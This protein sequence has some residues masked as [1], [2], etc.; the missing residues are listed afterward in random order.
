MRV[1][2]SH[3]AR[4]R[5]IAR[6]IERELESLDG[7]ATFRDEKNIAGGERITERIRGEI[8]A[9]DELVVIFSAASQVSSWVNIEIG[10]AW[11]FDKRIVF[12]LEKL[13]PTDVPVGFADL[14]LF[15]LNEFDGYRTDLQRRAERGVRA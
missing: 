3:S 10:A 5:W 7:V 2:I 4:D 8:F 14:R 9:C 15:D 1:F 6:Q 12:L 11:A 13:S